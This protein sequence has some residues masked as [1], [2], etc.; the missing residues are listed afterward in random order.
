MDR[1]N[2]T[3][4]MEIQEH[5]RYRDLQVFVYYLKQVDEVGIR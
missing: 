4:A 3:P 2:L 5:G 1:D